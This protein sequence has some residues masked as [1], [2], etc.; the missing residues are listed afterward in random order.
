MQTLTKI[1]VYLAVW[2]RP[3]ITELCFRG[4][5]RLQQH[6]DFSIQALAVISEDEMIPL[7]EKYGIAWVMYKNDP[8]GEKKNFG[9]QAAKGFDF[10][11]LMEIG[12]DDLILNELLED[13]KNYIGKH[14]FFGISDCAYINSESGECRR[15][16]SKSTYGAGRMISRKSLEAANWVLWNDRL[17]RGLD[18][19]SVFALQ[20]KN[21]AYHRV[22]QGEFP[23]VID[24]KS[25][26]NIWRF[27]YYLGVPYDIEEILK[28]ISPEE[29]EILESLYVTVEG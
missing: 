25:Q 23:C 22:K 5:K 8:L 12:S 9:L 13:Y 11:Y 3:E 17:N 28:R 1:L 2:K 21:I 16:I 6:L 19:N 20:R 26:Q 24:V 7:C 27:N 29:K 14:E 4:I 10:D 15:L 18:N